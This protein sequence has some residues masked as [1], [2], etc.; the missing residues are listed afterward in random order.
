MGQKQI[1]QKVKLG[2][3]VSTNEIIL[4]KY[5]LLMFGPKLKQITHHIIITK[6]CRLSKWDS[7]PRL[8]GLANQHTQTSRSKVAALVSLVLN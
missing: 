5:I 4:T 6:K 8:L 2:R 3:N 1:N 7:N